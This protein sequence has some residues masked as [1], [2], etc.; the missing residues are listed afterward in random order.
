MSNVR[1]L[2]PRERDPDAPPIARRPRPPGKRY[3]AHRQVEVNAHDRKLV[4]ADCE[5]DV[6]PFAFLDYL[7]HD[8]ERYTRAVA[9]AKAAAEVALAELADVKRQ[10]RNAK[11][12]RRRL[13]A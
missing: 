9:Q 11:A 4:C 6:D 13:Q 5:A 7:A 8:L 12:Q 10:L 2:K 3:C 1:E